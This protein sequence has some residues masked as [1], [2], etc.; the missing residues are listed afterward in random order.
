MKPRSN[1]FFNEVK[2]LFSPDVPPEAVADALYEAWKRRK[3]ENFSREF[4]LECV[5]YY[6]R[7]KSKEN[8]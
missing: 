1:D 2:T 5:R 4:A 3:M 8:N 6:I 7:K